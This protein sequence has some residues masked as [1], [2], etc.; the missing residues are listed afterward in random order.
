MNIN[1]MLSN[2]EIR[3]FIF[4]NNNKNLYISPRRGFKTL[5]LLYKMWYKSNNRSVNDF[6]RPVYICNSESQISMAINQFKSLLECNNISITY[7]VKRN[8]NIYEVKVNDLYY[9]FVSISY[10]NNDTDIRGKKY[11]DI[12]IDEP[13]TFEFNIYDKFLCTL[14]A[15]SCF[16]DKNTINIVGTMIYNKVNIYNLSADLSFKRFNNNHITLN[17][18]KE[19]INKMNKELS[20]E[21]FRTEILGEFV[22]KVINFKGE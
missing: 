6:N 16:S 4:S 7:I 20:Y 14:E 3:E 19:F 13:D 18:D 17:T 10:I 1:K 12:Y 22:N 5:S 9:E 15:L 11:S 8:R 21:T 2:Q